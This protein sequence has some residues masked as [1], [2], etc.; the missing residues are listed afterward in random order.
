MYVNLIVDSAAG[1]ADK[2]F[3][4]ACQKQSLEVGDRL[5]VPFGKGSSPKPALVYS[6]LKE[7]PDFKCKEIIAVLDKKYSFSKSQLYLIYLLRCHY[8]ATY[9]A[10]YR[11][12]LPSS[13]DLI[14][15]KKYLVK[16]DGFMQFNLGIFLLKRKSIN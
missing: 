3:T 9:R 15:I 12:I 14:I 10:A 13:Q 7:K 16:E 2:L 11:L 4:Y 8:A 5:V 1:Q 6:I